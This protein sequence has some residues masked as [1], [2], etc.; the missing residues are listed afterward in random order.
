MEG[1]ASGDEDGVRTGAVVGD[2]VGDEDEDE[3][4]DGA[5]AR[6]SEVCDGDGKV[7]DGS[8]ATCASNDAM[9]LSYP[10]CKQSPTFQ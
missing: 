8:V 6:E 9:T 10:R 5:G 4:E 2:G 3:D 7:D 1:D